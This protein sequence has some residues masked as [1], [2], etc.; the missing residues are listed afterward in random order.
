MF[1]KQ[2]NLLL[3]I[4]LSSMITASFLAISQISEKTLAQS[5]AGNMSKSASM[6]MNYNNKTAASGDMLMRL[7][8]TSGMNNASVT[9]L[10]NITAGISATR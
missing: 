5:N 1:R 7:G 2:S 6:M 8:H 3:G 10:G 4:L 9:S